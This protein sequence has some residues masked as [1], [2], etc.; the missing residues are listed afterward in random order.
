MAVQTWF[1]ILQTEGV[2]PAAY[3]ELYRRA[4]NQ[5]AFVLRQGREMPE[6][7]AQLMLSQWIGETGLRKELE[8]RKIREGRTLSQNAASSCK[9]CFG[10]GRRYKFD[11]ETGKTLGITGKCDHNDF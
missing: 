9:Y 10:T 6:M 5:Q 7:S 4:C 1:E 3:D 11:A 2:P 8:Q